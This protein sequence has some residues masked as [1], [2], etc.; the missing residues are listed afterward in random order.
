[1]KADIFTTTKK[2]LKE[3][4]DN[5]LNIDRPNLSENAID[6]IIRHYNQAVRN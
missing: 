3:I 6:F 5:E 1:M 4:F 2:I